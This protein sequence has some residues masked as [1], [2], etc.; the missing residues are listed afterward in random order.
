MK[1]VIITSKKCEELGDMSA[2]MDVSAAA[3]LRDR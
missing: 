3:L 2:P 1:I